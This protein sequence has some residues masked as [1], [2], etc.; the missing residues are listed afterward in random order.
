MNRRIHS[1]LFLWG[2]PSGF[3]VLLHAE[4]RNRL[5]DPQGGQ[6]RGTVGVPTFAHYPAHYSQRLQIRS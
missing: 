5:L 1:P 4:L 3:G 2:A 6:P